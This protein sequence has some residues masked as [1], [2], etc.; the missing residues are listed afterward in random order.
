MMNTSDFEYVLPPELIA[1]HPLPE[2]TD[3]RMMVVDRRA[4]SISH[5]HIRDFPG[6]LNPG[7]LL[8]ANNTR[9]I[10]AR[11][12]GSWRDTGG[13][14]EILLVEE[15]SEN[16]WRVMSRSARRVR[17]GQ[18]MLL[19]DE[20]VEGTVLEVDIGGRVLVQFSSERAFMEIVEARGVPPVPPYIQRKGN[21][22]P[23]V[24]LDRDRYQTVYA[25]EPGA[26][27]AP[28]AGLHFSKALL[29]E[30]EKR[31]ITCTEIT[32]HV[33]PGT[34]RPVKGESLAGHL[35][36]SERYRIS[37]ATAQIL[38]KART[39]AAR[40]IAIGTT[41]V[42]TL[43]SV[44]REKGRFVATTGKTAIFIYPPHSFL[45]VDVLLTNFHLPRSTLLML[46]AAFAADGISAQTRAVEGGLELML[47]AYQEAIRNEYRFYS[48]GDSMLII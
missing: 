4:G 33:G 26:I 47:A 32:L 20:Q 13:K 24:Q 16:L 34:F 29:D 7:D 31:G 11:L 28:T 22:D 14:V 36:E 2:R 44:M 27:A 23:L 18:C 3:S 12:F 5:K 46:V 48:Y 30:I 8:V 42:R 6:Y 45:A 17:A 25:C 40:T 19:C 9:V 35:M 43:E 39:G 41:T 10:P 38:E 21:S 1:Q 37:Q 15:V